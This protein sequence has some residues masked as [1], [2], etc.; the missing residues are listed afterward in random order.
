MYVSYI[1]NGEYFHF[2]HFGQKKDTAQFRARQ[3][4]WV[5][6]WCHINLKEICC[7]DVV[8]F[9]SVIRICPMQLY[10]RMHAWV[11]QC[12]T[13]LCYYNQDLTILWVTLFWISPSIMPSLWMM[14]DLIVVLI[15]DIKC[16]WRSVS[17][18]FWCFSLPMMLK[19]SDR[20]STSC[21]S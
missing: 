17:F 20:T 16:R 7:G 19:I 13:V 12:L 3:H 21:W 5:S 10:N 15:H 11:F 18:L 8:G 1:H 6:V 14:L 9:Y 2:Y 4:H